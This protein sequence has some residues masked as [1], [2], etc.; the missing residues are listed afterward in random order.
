MV[1]RNQGYLGKRFKKTYA[2]KKQYQI[3]AVC[4]QIEYESEFELELIHPKFAHLEVFKKTNIDL[5]LQIFTDHG[6]TFLLKNN[7]LFN[8][9]SRENIHYFQGKVS[10]LIVQEIHKK[11]EEEWMGVFHASA[12]G[13]GNKSMLFLGDSGKGKSTCLALL[14][15]NGFDCIA[16]DFVPISKNEKV[17]SFP[18]AI[19]VKKSSWKM[20]SKYYPEIYSQKEYYF[21][22]H[23]KT[24]KYLP[25]SNQKS[26]NAFQCDTLVFIRYY[27]NIE[28]QLQSISNI[29]AFERLLPD[30]W[31]SNRKENVSVFLNW[32]SQTKCYS[33]SYSNNQE[34]FDVVK[35]LYQNEL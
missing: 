29:E 25:P 33:L 22:S 17:Y 31:I 26:D 7:I 16:D 13:D 12:V 24:V 28:T 2:F 34:M 11:N 3:D 9:W 1:K 18:S 4:I 23:N 15:A 20:L 19:S 14:Q 10:M 35:K 8:D 21:S 5:T 6:H 32:F 27:E 30:S